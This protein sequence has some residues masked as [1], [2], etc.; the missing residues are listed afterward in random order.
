MSGLSD[1]YFEKQEIP[2]DLHADLMSTD[3]ISEDSTPSLSGKDLQGKN[4]FN[5]KVKTQ[6]IRFSAASNIHVGP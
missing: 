5:V 2:N 4:M 1:L 3:Y 6:L